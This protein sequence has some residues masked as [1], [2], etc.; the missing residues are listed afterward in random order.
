MH[1]RQHGVGVVFIIP[2]LN[3]MSNKIVRKNYFL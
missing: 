3:I 2:N 1:Q